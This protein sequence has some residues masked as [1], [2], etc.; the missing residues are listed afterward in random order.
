M[1][2]VN[3][4][5]ER[6]LG[7]CLAALARQRARFSFDVWVVDN[8]SS[9]GSLALL[10]RDHPQVRV[11]RNADNRGFAGGNNT[12]L[13]EVTT[14]Y[15]VLLNNDAVPEPDWLERLLAPFD[16][17]G[18]QR[19]A[20]VT[21][22]VVFAPRFLRLRLAVD[23]FVPGGADRRQLGVRIAS[24]AVDGED[25]TA[26]VLWERL[27]YGPEGTGAGR[28]WWTRPAGELLLPLPEH[29][30]P[31]SVAVRW[32]AERAKD[33]GLSW[34]GGRVALP[35][36][37]TMTTAS[38]T[39][40]AGTALVDVV[41]N[42]GSVVLTAGYGADRGYQDV[43]AGQYDAPADV[44]ALCGCA[45]ALRTDAGRAAGWFD[46]DFFLY[47][48]DTDL[49]WR[50][51]AAGWSIRYEPTAVVRH[52]HSATSVEWSPTFVFHTDRNRL[53][54]LVKNA[55]AGRAAREVARYPLTTGS[56]AL[57]TVRTAA[58]ARS[59][60]A[61]RPTLLRLRVLASLLRL[62]PTMLRRRT[63]RRAV[64]RRELERWLVSAR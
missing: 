14:P 64:P 55:T 37:S 36:T 54:M 63:G 57:R 53:L 62:L 33:V 9:D 7:P 15:A 25:V 2:V 28:T 52:V 34:D 43:D 19:L 10:A 18:A 49:S 27:T 60:P 5:G 59:R 32:S 38:W 42:A 17:P 58:R 13:R 61:V 24:V 16:A 31:W 8:A 3:W 44:F 48:E 29:G 6:W 56:I 1:V 45:V 46:E 51:R 4:N 12:A 30:G 39:V 50:L 23:G 26:G 40:P 47:Y 11:L 22:K 35:V 21:S 41:N 20:A